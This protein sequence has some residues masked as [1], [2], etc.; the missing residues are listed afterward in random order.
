MDERELRVCY[1]GTYR[2]EYSRNQIM[3]EGLRRSGVQVVECHVQLWGGIEDRVQAASGGWTN[4]RFFARVFSAYVELLHK[5]RTV[6]HYDVMVVGYPGQFDVYLARLLTWLQRKPLVWDVFMSIY[7]IAL[8]RGLEQ[9][10][11]LTVGMIRQMEWLAC[12]LPDLLIIDTADYSQWFHRTHGVALSRFRLVPTGADDRI[13]KP[14]T[15]QGVDDGLFHV[16]YYGTF[17]PNHG[18]EYIIEAAR[19]MA[20]DPMVRFELIGTGPDKVKA[21]R[22]AQRYGLSNVIFTDWLDQA[23]LSRRAARAEVCL[24]AFG[25]TPQ[26]MMTIQN[27]IYEGL[28]MARPVISG[29]SPAVRKALTH[30]KHI[31]LCKRADPQ[32][33]AEAIRALKSDPTLCKRLAENGQCLFYEQF[34]LAHK[35]QCFRHHLEEMV[36]HCSR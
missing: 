28:A 22:L 6:G 18:V 33:L 27:K 5:Y 26:S 29:D 16:V 21:L 19:L 7:L 20:D 35:G 12:R 14:V 10:S 32:S 11:A 34:D 9:R 2:A 23:E 1:F 3:V 13:F 30:G 17:I 25:A 8:E 24:G 4:L 36:D 31:Y 15:S